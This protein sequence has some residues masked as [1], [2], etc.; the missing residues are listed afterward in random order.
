MFTRNKVMPFPC[1]ATQECKTAYDGPG[2][3]F[4]YTLFI[5]FMSRMYGQHHCYRT[6]DQDKRHHTYKSQW[7]ISM[8]SARE[9]IEYHVWIGPEILTKTD[10]SVRDQESPECKC[11]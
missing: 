6:D 9:G 2:Q 4:Y 1:L 7:Q 11:I 5:A 10:R 3:P 8:T